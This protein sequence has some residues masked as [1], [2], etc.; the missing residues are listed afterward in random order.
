MSDWNK[1][2]EWELNWHDNCINSLYE[3]EKQIVYAEKMGLV[4]TPNAKTPYVFNLNG[5][6]VLDIGGGAYS[7]L[8]KCINFHTDLSDRSIVVDPLM[9]KHPEWVRERYKCLGVTTL[10]IKGEEMT[11][12][13]LDMLG[14]DADFIYDEVWI[15]N[16]LEHC[17]DPEK[18]IKNAL[19]LG[20]I[21][22]LFEWIETSLG[23][24]VGHIHSFKADQLDAWLGGQGKVELIK[25]GG[26][27]GL[28]YYGIF[29]GES[30]AT[31]RS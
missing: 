3:E 24:N 12:S 7:L 25:R 5:A 13:V 2:Q 11:R 26:A 18:V 23:V 10:S 31:S 9:D 21:V 4:R 15:Y 6:S 19:K 14:F 16:V 27:N 29:K 30:Y 22:R 8:L 28:A 20:K 17:E 1:A